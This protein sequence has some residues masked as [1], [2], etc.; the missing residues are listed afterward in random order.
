MGRA[1]GPSQLPVLLSSEHRGSRRPGRRKAGFLL[2]R[3]RHRP[4]SLP[5]ARSPTHPRRDRKSPNTSR[6]SRTEGAELQLTLTVAVKVLPASATRRAG[7]HTAS[8]CCKQEDTGTGAAPHG[9]TA[10]RGE[11]G[12]AHGPGVRPDHS[13]GVLSHGGVTNSC[14]HSPRPTAQNLGG[15]PQFQPGP[16]L[17]A[18]VPR[19]D[20]SLLVD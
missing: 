20:G 15:G 6:V 5:P 16:R 13:I 12:H 17:G 8:P 4:A 9:D 10:H 19:G 18:T 1:F 7:T 11:A 2:P 14:R 3:R